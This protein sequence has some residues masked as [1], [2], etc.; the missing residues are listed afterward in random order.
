MTPV[1]PVS[2]PEYVRLVNDPVL[3]VVPPIAPGAGNTAC[4]MAFGVAFVVIPPDT[5]GNTSDPG[6]TVVTAGSA[7][8]FTLA[9]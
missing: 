3:G 9:I 8:I 6:T 1:P 5:S 4:T 2:V 7:E